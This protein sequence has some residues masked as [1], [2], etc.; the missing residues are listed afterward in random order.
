MNE[1]PAGPASVPKA[2]VCRKVPDQL[3]KPTYLK[4]SPFLVVGICIAPLRAPSKIGMR[5]LLP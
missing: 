3:M 1:C 4:T 2:Q 5:D